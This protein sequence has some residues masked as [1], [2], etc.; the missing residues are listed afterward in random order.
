MPEC[1]NCSAEL[2][3]EWNFCVYC[4]TPA[5]PWAVPPDVVRR[6]GKFNPLAI[7]AFVLASLGGFPALVFGHIAMVQ[8]A[9]SGERGISLARIATVLGYVWLATG[10]VL[11]FLWL[12]GSL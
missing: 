11:L 9:Q 2:R 12:S 3:R 5:V 1:A 8:I 4:G 10:L 6:E 7:L